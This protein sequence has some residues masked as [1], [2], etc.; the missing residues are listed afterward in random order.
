MINGAVGAF[1]VH[2]HRPSHTICGVIEVGED[3]RHYG[4]TMSELADV[5]ADHIRRL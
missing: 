1:P 5:T 2:K 3:D 4:I